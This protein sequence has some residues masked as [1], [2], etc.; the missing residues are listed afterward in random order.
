MPAPTVSGLLAEA[1]ARLAAAG[2][3]APATDARVLLAHVLGFSAARVLAAGETPVA[4]ADA[5]RFRAL[6]ARRA[7]REPVAY[8]VGV[9]EFYGLPLLVTPAVLVPRPETEGVVA[10]VLERLP[11]APRVWDAGTG[12]G[13]IAVAV[14]VARADARVVASDRSPAALSVCAANARRHGVSSRVRPVLADWLDAAADASL[15]VVASNPPYVPTEELAGLP[16]EIRDYEPRAALDGGPDGLDGLR[17]V[18]SGAR[19]A[20]RRGG[21]LAAEVGPGQADAALGLVRAAGGW[22]EAAVLPDLA[23]LPRVLVARRG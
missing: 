21:R 12:S 13:A 9:R 6:V 2:V 19:R 16:P 11:P 15:D 3:D 5:A 22:D 10:A 18:V 4:P 23:G 14:A 20:L 8:L 1:R 7:A 17:R